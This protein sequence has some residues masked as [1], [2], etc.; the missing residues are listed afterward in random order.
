MLYIVNSK[1]H[2]IHLLQWLLLSW[3]GNFLM[4]ELFISSCM[5]TNKQPV[6]HLSLITSKT[7][8]EKY[9][10]INEINILIITVMNEWIV[11]ELYCRLN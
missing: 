5:I 2:C 8:R 1:T 3:F 10:I 9:F 4:F 7:I 11:F 6:I